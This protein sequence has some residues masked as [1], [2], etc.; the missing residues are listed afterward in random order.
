[1][2]QLYDA[3][4]FDCYGTLIDWETGI[5]TAIQTAAAQDGVELQRETI[6]AKYHQVE[7]TVQAEAYQSYKTVLRD[8]AVALAREVGW[9]LAPERARFLPD[10]VADWAPF[11][12]TNAALERLKAAGFRLGILSNVDDDLLEGTLRRLSSEF[13]FLITAEQVR[14][15]KPAH[16]HFLRARELLGGSRWLHV[17]Q[18]LFH[19]IVPAGTLGIPVAWVNRKREQP[20]GGVRPIAE[21]K[22]LEE[23]VRWLGQK[24]SG[25]RGAGSAQ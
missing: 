15:Y 24:G 16:A 10:S 14:S 9:E 23:L 7:P 11:R 25:E 4:T 17:A 13:D 20:L 18:S 1:M 8:V 22:T 3:L 2:S 21:V 5:T 19:D 6:V 12:D